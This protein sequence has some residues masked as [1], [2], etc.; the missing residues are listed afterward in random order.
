MFSQVVSRSYSAVLLLPDLASISNIYLQL[1]LPLLLLLSSLC[2]SKLTFQLQSS[3][4]SCLA[5]LLDFPQVTQSPV[6]HEAEPSIPVR[7]ILLS[8]SYLLIPPQQYTQ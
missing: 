4:G 7:G 1:F 2:R 8:L 3:Q 5:F 6:A